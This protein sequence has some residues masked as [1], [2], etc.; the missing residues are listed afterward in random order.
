MWT[1]D[2]FA[3][4][5]HALKVDGAQQVTQRPPGRRPNIHRDNAKTLLDGEPLATLGAA[6]VNHSPTATTFHADKKAMRART[7]DFGRL[8]GAFHESVPLQVCRQQARRKLRTQ[9]S[10]V[11]LAAR[12]GKSRWLTCRETR[13]HYR[14]KSHRGGMRSDK[15]ARSRFGKP[16]IRPKTP[17]GVKQGGPNLTQWRPMRDAA[18]SCG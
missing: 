14:K 2:A 4:A 15:P 1:L 13:R 8:I 16:D 9:A 18:C 7:P 6:R 12:H 10:Q 5:E 11:A 17:V 3:S